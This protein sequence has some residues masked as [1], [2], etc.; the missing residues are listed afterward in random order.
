MTV[1]IDTYVTVAEADEFIKQYYPEFDD[2]AVVWGVLTEREKTSYLY[3]SL[4][5]IE[6]LVLQGKPL[7]RN[8]PLQFPRIKCF[9]PATKENPTIPNEVKE[10]QIENALE[11]LNA[12]LGARSDEQMILLSALGVV[13][14]TKYNKR[15]MGEVGLGATLT[16]AESRTTL[17]S[18]HA[19]KLLK[20]WY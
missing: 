7:D 17:E 3:T 13:K 2:L 5:Q 12:D 4:Q 20:A 1:G 19:V 14:N 16:G 18:A 6:A 15:E 9:K 8:Q 10:A 11:L